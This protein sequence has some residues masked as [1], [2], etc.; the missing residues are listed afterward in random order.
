MK[1]ASSN[2][3]TTKRA[4]GTASLGVVS[5]TYSIYKG[6]HFNDAPTEVAP[7]GRVPTAREYMIGEC[8]SDTS[9]G[10]VDLHPPWGGDQPPHPYPLVQRGTGGLG[11]HHGATETQYEK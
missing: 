7:P 3:S 6:P 9:R 11:A 1:Y 8:S 5:D 10:P 2:R 4:L